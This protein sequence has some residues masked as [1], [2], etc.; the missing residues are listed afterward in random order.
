MCSVGK[1]RIF[2]QR[3]DHLRVDL[4]RIQI[5]CCLCGQAKLGNIAVD[6][7]GNISFAKQKVGGDVEHT[8]DADDALIPQL[9]RLAADETA[10]TALG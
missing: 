9:V 1:L 5:S 2:K 3:V 6:A 7:V 10:E 8:G 4:V